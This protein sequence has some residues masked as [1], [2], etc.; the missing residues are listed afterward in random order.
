MGVEVRRNP[1]LDDALEEA[2]VAIWAAV[3]NAGGAVGFVPP[4]TPEDVVPTARVAFDRVRDGR[5][6]LVVAFDG[7]LPSGFGFLATNDT[8]LKRHFGTVVRLQ[9]HPEWAGRGVGG[10]VLDALEQAARDRGF[11]RVVLTVRA[12]TG[13]ERFYQVRGY[14]LEAVLPGR[15]A[16]GEGRVVDELH[17]SKWVGPAP[18]APRGGVLLVQR[19]DPDVPLPRYAHPDDAGLD[20]HAS[21]AVTLQPGERTLVP[22]GLAIALPQGHVGLVHP[23]SGLALRD[24]VGMVNAPGTIDEG[25][26]G[27]LAVILINHDA[28][29]PVTLA[30]GDRIAQLVVQPVTH[31]QVVEADELPDS[32]RGRGGFGSSGR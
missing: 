32:E 20:L 2:L 25:Y 24:G 1:P 10:A 23:R 3:T 17:L 11:E 15:L 31:V 13:T 12:G 7:A 6:D 5:D 4:V 27:E 19:L 30:R 14:A 9:R 16:I 21:E 22:T 26:R 28:H 8:A 29:E 18:T